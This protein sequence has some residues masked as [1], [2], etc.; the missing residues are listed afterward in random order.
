MNLIEQ[1]GG[2]EKAKL[3]SK[4]IDIRSNHY[5]ALKKC[6]LQHRRQNNIFEVGDKVI[7]ITSYPDTNVLEIT[8]IQDNYIVAE[9][10]ATN[11]TYST[12]KWSIGFYL[13]HATDAEIEAGVRLCL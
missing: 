4:K 2:Y 10:G 9:G 5:K 6:L 3:M 7:E 13:R 12:T 11:A 8:V 1:L